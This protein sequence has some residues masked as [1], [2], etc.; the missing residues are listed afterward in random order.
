MEDR[1]IDMIEFQIEEHRQR[2]AFYYRLADA[3]AIY[4]VDTVGELPVPVYEVFADE[5]IALD[6]LPSNVKGAIL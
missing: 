5:A 6:I 2:S 4:G 1:Q 3:L